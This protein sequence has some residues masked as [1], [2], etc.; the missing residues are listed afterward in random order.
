MY[1]VPP[2]EPAGQVP[3]GALSAAWTQPMWPRPGIS[4]APATPA[5]ARSMRR[6]DTTGAVRLGNPTFD[7]SS[8][9]QVDDRLRS[10]GRVDRD[11]RGAVD[12]RL[13]W[14]LSCSVQL[15]RQLSHKSMTTL[16]FF[17]NTRRRPNENLWQLHLAVQHRR[18]GRRTLRRPGG[19]ACSAPGS[20]VRRSLIGPTLRE[21]RR[22]LG[23]TQSQLAAD[24]G[25]SASYLNL[26]ES[27]KRNIGGALLKRLADAL[28][29]ALDELDGAAE[30]RL[31]DDL[32]E[33][34]AEPLLAELRLDAAATHALASQHR[35]WAHALVR[36]HR[37]WRDRGRAV[38]ALSDRLNQDPFLAGAVHSMLTQVAAIR[39]ASEI[40]ETVGDL[41]P[42]QRQQFV[43]IVGNESAQIGR[44]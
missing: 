8:L 32:G 28:G 14:H 41:E 4:V 30:R 24:A 25:I 23:I 33:L 12:R 19:S 10:S 17:V 1:T 11:G 38:S 39:S 9:L 34:A 43:A 31:Q 3:I 36:L 22:A 21:R 13:R 40:V 27:D 29:L 18:R 5:P 16:E 15:F 42:A 20:S 44:A 6:R 7:M 26:I 37:A 35:N 2:C